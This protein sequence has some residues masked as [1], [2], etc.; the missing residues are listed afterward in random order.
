MEDKVSIILPVFNDEKNIKQSID[1]VLNQS[2]KNFELIIIDDCSNDSTGKL[3]SDYNDKRIKIFKNNNNLG[4]ANSRNLGIDKSTGKYIA[5]IDSDDAWF[6]NKLKIQIDF[7]KRNKINFTYSGVLFID[8]N[9]KIIGEYNPRINVKY[10]TL[11]KYNYIPTITIVYLKT[12]FQE[13]RFDNIKHEDFLFVLT[14]TKSTIF[15]GKG[16]SERLAFYRIN[17]SSTSFNKIKAAK[18]HLTVLKRLEKNK[19]MLLYFLI[20]Y[21]L[22]GLIKY[23]NSYVKILSLPHK[24]KKDN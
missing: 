15:K 24:Y 22:N 18:W 10:R 16:I 3:I 4:I 20:F 7:I 9:G 1:S 8:N 19:I 21:L 12:A 2:Y 11:I 5:F 14:I 17:D 13:L 23:F 6:E